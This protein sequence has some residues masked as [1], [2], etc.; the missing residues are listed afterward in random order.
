MIPLGEIDDFRECPFRVR[1]DEDMGRLAESIREMGVITP[2][3]VRK[4]EDG[5]YETVSGHRR[6]K[7][8][9]MAGLEMIPAQVRELSR[10]QAIIIMVDSNLHRSEILPSE[11]AFAY[12][13]KLEAMNRQGM[14]TDLTLCPADTKWDSGRELAKKEG[15]SRRQIF[16]YIRLTELTPELLALVDEKKIGMRPAVELSYLTLR[17]QRYLYDAIG[18]NDATPSHAQ[19]IRMKNF[20][21]EGRLSNEVIAS[22]MMEEK[23]NQKEKISLSC[24]RVRKYI[25]ESVPY[26]KTADYIYRA[27]EYYRQHL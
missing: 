11:K 15:A 5:R 22:I 1:M 9:E 23:P 18:Y 19:A 27:L 6:K 25:P 4:K 24:A 16:R 8:A 2:L 7:A 20:S 26:E 14:R 12:K 21:R 3:L 17:E 13:M 10:D